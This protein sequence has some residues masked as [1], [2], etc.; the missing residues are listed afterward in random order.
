MKKTLSVL[1]SLL[2]VLSFVLSACS[3]NA[4][5]KEN[6][7]DTSKEQSTAQS[8][9]AS[10]ETSEDT[11]EEPGEGSSQD[12]PAS[13]DSSEDEPVE[14]VTAKYTKY[15]PENHIETHGRVPD[16][17]YKLVIHSVEELRAYLGDNGELDDYGYTLEESEVYVS[18]NAYE[19]YDE[20]YF[21][22]NILLLILIREYYDTTRNKVYSVTQRDG[23][24]DVVLENFSKDGWN[25]DFS[26]VYWSLFIELDKSYDVAPEHINVK[27]GATYS[28]T[29]FHSLQARYTPHSDMKSKTFPEVHI[30]RTY[31]EYE[32]YIRT[33][34]YDYDA[35]LP[36]IDS[37]NTYYNA[38]LNYFKP[39]FFDNY[40]VVMI[41]TSAPTQHVRFKTTGLY[42]VKL[43][44]TSIEIVVEEIE[45]AGGE[46]TPA[47]W[48]IPVTVSKK[49]FNE[50]RFN[51]SYKKAENKAN[52]LSFEARNLRTS[53]DNR[54][55]K[56]V[57]LTSVAEL[58]AFYQEYKDNYQLDHGYASPHVP[59]FKT[60]MED[61]DEKFFAKENLLI[62]P[63]ESGSGSVHFELTKLTL[64]EE[65]GKHS[66]EVLVKAYAPQM[67]TD[68]MAYWFIMAPVDKSYDIDEVNLDVE[69][70]HVSGRE[71]SNDYLV[72]ELQ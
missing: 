28:G 46:G 40:L 11:S 55:A 32:E 8:T 18:F 7:K 48:H 39:H 15:I 30:I 64:K 5:E 38:S 14:T 42:D 61:F 13:E 17:G 2:L 49:I 37:Y 1:L 29:L 24:V 22:D 63:V 26:M 36:G 65:N 62:V 25:D 47:C 9:E 52:E 72:F 53:W 68:D 44:V 56:P 66:L 6:S 41:V 59:P 70:V 50:D 3:G 60:V 23:Y 58:E 20:E 4:T 34:G 33:S 12:E 54:D 27:K 67:Q 21:K 43:G 10:A 71:P 31:E 69:Y 19:L 45:V 57:L 35:K 16:E 51:V